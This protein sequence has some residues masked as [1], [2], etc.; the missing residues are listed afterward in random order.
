MSDEDSRHVTVPSVPDDDRTRRRLGDETKGRIADLASGWSVDEPA[1]PNVEPATKPRGD[2]TNARIAELASGWTVDSADT[3][4][5]VPAMAAPEPPPPPRKKQKTLPPPP[6]GSQERKALEAAIL[7]ANTGPAPKSEPVRAKPPTAPPPLPAAAKKATGPVPA[8]LS[9]AAKKAT[10]P[11]PALQPPSKSGANAKPPSTVKSGPTETGTVNVSGVIGGMTPAP[12][13]AV[14]PGLP[15]IGKLPAGSAIK[16]AL[17]LRAD[18]TDRTGPPPTLPAATPP[19]P[20]PVAAKPPISALPPDESGESTEVDPNAH[21]T[22]PVGEFDHGGTLLE[23]DK[24]RIAYEQST[25]KRDAASALL[26]LPEQPLT[27]VKAPPV[28]VLLGESAAQITRGDPTSIEPMTEKFERADPTLGPDATS[29]DPPGATPG[30]G[31]KLRTQAALRRKRGI[32]G[33]VR[34]VATAVLGVRRARHELGEL[35]LQQATRQKSRARHLLTLGRAAVG[36]EGYDHPAL[37]KA[38]ESLAIVEDERAQHAASVT[39]ADSELMRVRTD[40]AE[41]AKACAEAIAKLDAELADIA[42]KLEPLEKEVASAAR[43]AGELREA[44]R[45]VDAKIAATEASK[46]AV[47]SQKVDP[48]AIQAELATLKADRLAVERDEPKIAAELDALNPR[49]AA[50]EARRAEARK[51]RIELE[52]EEKQDQGR[53]QELLAAIGAKRKVVDR[54]AA[55]AE[56]MRD[57]IL[58]EL[59]ERIY[60]ERPTSM[61]FELSPV[62]AIDVELGVTDRR[63]MELKEIISSVDKAKLARGV[64]VIILVLGAAGAFV[65]WLLYMLG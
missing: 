63:M 33:D 65:A 41:K 3:P 23:Q 29:I 19:K 34:Y 4:E 62:D 21:L 61:Q 56:Q 32:G 58:L 39:A 17:P 35:E 7:D 8:L 9:T 44:L 13:R 52:A 49:V 24:L 1:K 64:A 27:V 30:A 40:R 12:M 5:E 48:A 38:R 50:L 26:G 20:P 42:K 60:V 53:A 2:E 55:D 51:R 18:T 6:P 37:N 10:G 43:K 22:V 14:N 46:V 45:R 25:I 11:V 28:E 47:R 36:S 16:D 54:A 59:G 57:K 15:G 31:G